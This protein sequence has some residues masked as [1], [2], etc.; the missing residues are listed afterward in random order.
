[1]YLAELLYWHKA[2]RALCSDS[3]ALL[4]VPRTKLKYYGDKS[5]M[6]AAPILWNKLPLII[7]KMSELDAVKRAVETHLYRSAFSD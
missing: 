5:F 1:M 3:E 6:K 2:P 7:R 4:D